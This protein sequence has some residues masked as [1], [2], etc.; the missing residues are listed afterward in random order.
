MNGKIAARVVR[1][2]SHSSISKGELMLRFRTGV[3]ALFVLSITLPIQAQSPLTP[4][5]VS[6]LDTFSRPAAPASPLDAARP[7]YNPNVFNPAMG[8]VLDATMGDT[9]E[10]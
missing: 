1:R 10:R 4:T 7:G 2:F 3:F 5:Q 9:R 8:L 6:P